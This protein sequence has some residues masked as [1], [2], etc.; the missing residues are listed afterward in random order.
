MAALIFCGAISQIS[1]APVGVGLPDYYTHAQNVHLYSNGSAGF[2]LLGADNSCSKM[3]YLNN[4]GLPEDATGTTLSPIT[5]DYPYLSA[6]LQNNKIYI[7]GFRKQNADSTDSGVLLRSYQLEQCSNQC[8]YYCLLG[9][10]S[11]LNKQG[12]AVDCNENTYTLDCVENKI[13]L[14]NP[15]SKALS[16]ISP[17]P[18]TSGTP[19]KYTSICISPNQYLYVTYAAGSQISV[20]NVKNNPPSGIAKKFNSDIP[21]LPFRFLNG[22]TA[23]D[24]NGTVFSASGAL[25]VFHKLYNTNGSGSTACMLESGSIVCKTATRTAKKFAADGTV[26][27]EYNF[28]GELLDLA[29]NGTIAAAVVR[30]DTGLR[31]VDLGKPTTNGSH[32]EISSEDSSDSNTGI[33][34]ENIN[35]KPVSSGLA[36]QSSSAPPQS[37]S[38]QVLSTPAG[39]DPN[40]PS[41]SSS[42]SSS[43][44]TPQPPSCIQSS[45]Y[46]ID[47]E[48]GQIYMDT[49]VSFTQL[50]KNIRSQGA[51]LRAVKPNGTVISSGNVG[52][53]T[54]I[55]L[56]ANGKLI[57]SVTVVVKGDLA[58]SGSITKRDERILYSYLNSGYELNGPYLQAAD[59]NGDGCVDTLD[60]LL[61]KRYL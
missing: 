25:P 27:A 42:S 29:S 56:Q 20:I 4:K 59:M 51:V 48:E 52:T 38:S 24:A 1:P 43:S 2:I 57:D 9:G 8:Y 30:C 13:K 5:L 11:G 37:S 40:E 12:I 44:Q 23:I 26:T 34:S 32:S 6:F 15:I 47:R 54:V 55:E 17:A 31:F 16:S 14:Y 10:I 49:P 46:R 21:V 50:K 60:L 36:S 3:T 7:A 18:T 53:G 28:D 45:S 58:G 41:E 19:D 39:S 61:L 33:S 35:S 22:S